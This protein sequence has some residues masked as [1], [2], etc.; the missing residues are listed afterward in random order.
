MPLS[1]PNENEQ[2]RI[3]KVLTL[4]DERIAT[5]RKVIER[6]ETLI[7]GIRERLFCLPN[8]EVPK[9]RCKGYTSPYKTYKLGECCRR[10]TRKNKYNESDLVLT[11]AAKKGMVAQIE[12]FNNSVASNNLHNYYLL[13]KGDFAY[14][15]SYS[16]DY[17][18]GAIKPLVMYDKGVLSSLYI[19]FRPNEALLMPEYLAHYFE[20]VKWHKGI[21]DIAGEGARN[22]GLLNISIEDFFNTMHRFPKLDEQVAVTRLLESIDDK[23]AQEYAILCCY[24]KQRT[25]L[26]SNLFI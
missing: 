9:M 7:N 3:A 1:L 22:H 11:I 8:R 24:E 16:T 5:Q 13:E 12:Y 2:N 19:C 15:K 14:N 21:K 20:T 23:I 25:Y 10:V 4:L 6:L 18:W 17:P 26:L